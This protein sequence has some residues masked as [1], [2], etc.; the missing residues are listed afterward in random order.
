MT[1][2]KILSNFK[3]NNEFFDK[4]SQSQDFNSETY[5][6]NSERTNS[7]VGNLLQRFHERGKELIEKAKS[8]SQ[9]HT[10]NGVDERKLS[11]VAGFLDGDGTINVSTSK[12]NPKLGYRFPFKFQLTLSFIQTKKRLACLE[13]LQ[14]LLGGVGNIREKASVYEYN[15]TG[16]ENIKDILML[17]LPYLR[18]K[19]R[20]A[21]LALIFIE[22]ETKGLSSVKFLEKAALVEELSSYNDTKNRVYTA[23]FI[24]ETMIERGMLTAEE[25]ELSEFI[26]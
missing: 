14:N 7:K 13:D 23:K 1:T 24:K 3:E 26:V 4:L 18:V 5:L 6:I 10:K 22:S 12:T 20:Q 9:E 17:L 2:N 16:S 11:Y 15:I 8:L 21:A 25:Q 19:K